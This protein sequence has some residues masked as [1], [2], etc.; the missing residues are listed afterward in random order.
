MQCYTASITDTYSLLSYYLPLDHCLSL[1]RPASCCAQLP[2]TVS[3]PPCCACGR[4]ATPSHSLAPLLSS[5]AYPGRRGNT[6][7]AGWKSSTMESG[8]RCATMTSPSTLPKW[9][10]ESLAS[11]MPSPGRPRPSTEEEKVKKLLS[12]IWT[13]YYPIKT[14]QKSSLNHV[15][16]LSK[17]WGEG[18]RVLTSADC[19]PANHTHSKAVHLFI[20]F[21]MFHGN[22]WMRCTFPPVWLLIPPGTGFPI[23]GE[24]RHANQFWAWGGWDWKHWVCKPDTHTHTDVISSPLTLSSMNSSVTV[25][26]LMRFPT[27]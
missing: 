25:K 7:R 6:T 9:C 22:L 14:L 3:C 16:Q 19:Q 12:I 1:P 2:S 5:Y 23:R 20:L 11:W 18:Y 13:L 8:G 15:I 27:L 24:L 10:A 4:C 21:H 17:N 26:T